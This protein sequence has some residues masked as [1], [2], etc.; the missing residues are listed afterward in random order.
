MNACT[1]LGLFHPLTNDFCSPANCSEQRLWETN[2]NPC[3]SRSLSEKC[4]T[5]YSISTYVTLH[6][7]LW[8]IN[9]ING[10]ASHWLTWIS[11]D[12]DGCLSASA[13]IL[14]LNTQR[15]KDKGENSHTN[16]VALSHAVAW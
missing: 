2:Q 12:G 10:V 4:C 14:W 1:Y 13:L 3:K 11:K 6:Q 8:I 15:H 5:T 16:N 9:T 7:T